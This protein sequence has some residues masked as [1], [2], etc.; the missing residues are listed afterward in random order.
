MRTVLVD[1]LHVSEVWVGAN[2]LFGHERS[3][4]FTLLRTLGQRY[5]FRAEKIDPVRY[6]EFVVS[7]TRIRR[8]VAEGAH[9]R[10]GARCSAIPTRW[11]ARSSRDGGAA[12]SWG[13]PP[14]TCRPTTS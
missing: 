8:L 7:S 1:W 2:F 5:G 12:A 9:G 4:N 11:P 6:K 13:F 3:G 14:P 10:G